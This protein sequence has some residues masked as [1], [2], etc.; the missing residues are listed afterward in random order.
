MFT[1]EEY[2]VRDTFDIYDFTACNINGRQGYTADYFEE[3]ST[4][5][6]DVNW[7]TS[8]HVREAL[9][10]GPLLFDF[11][12]RL[13]PLYKCGRISNPYPTTNMNGSRPA[14]LVGYGIDPD[15]GKDYWIAKGWYGEQWGENGYFRFAAHDTD[16][17][18]YGVTYRSYVRPG[19]Y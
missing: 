18:N 3:N 2:P 7:F 10:R 16:L 11:G 9:T 17:F 5:T 8:K 13:D 6:I 1:T 4:N 19:F 14:I 15:T 12:R